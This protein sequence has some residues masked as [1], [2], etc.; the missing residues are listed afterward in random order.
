MT[1][2]S[3]A[4][5]LQAAMEMVDMDNT[6]SSSHKDIR[7]SEIQH[8]EADVK[9]V[10]DA[11]SNFVNPP[12]VENKDLLYCISSGAPAPTDVEED[13]FLADMSGNKACDEFIEDCLIKKTASFFYPVK[14]Q[15]LKTFASL[16][17][18]V[19]LTGSEKK[20]K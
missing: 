6:D 13:L 18:Y 9:K 8:S 10:V 2:H 1:R 11:I 4:Q 7:K 17:K 16:A 15:R 12:E 5:Y 19:K 14:K 20:S 3:R